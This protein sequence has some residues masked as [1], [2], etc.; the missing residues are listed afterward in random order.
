MNVLCSASKDSIYNSR[1]SDCYQQS[2]LRWYG[3]RGRSVRGEGAHLNGWRDDVADRAGDDRATPTRRVSN[4]TRS[5]VRRAARLS[6]AAYA[7]Q[8][9]NECVPLCGGTGTGYLS[10]ACAPLL[11]LRWPR[12]L[13]ARFIGYGVCPP[14]IDVRTEAPNEP[15]D[16]PPACA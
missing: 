2:N 13:L 8:Q 4:L 9:A 1:R 11:K 14:R 12:R 3:A 15:R 16:E 7:N 5:V 6:N 10:S